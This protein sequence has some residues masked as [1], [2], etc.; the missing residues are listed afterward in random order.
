MKH[1]MITA[2][3]VALLACEQSSRVQDC[4]SNEIAC[5]YDLRHI[6]ITI[7]ENDEPVQLT[8]MVV[9][10]D[11]VIQINEE[12][13]DFNEFGTYTLLSDE[14]M[15][16]VE[17]SGSDVSFS[18]FRGDDRVIDQNYLVGHDC[19]HIQLLEGPIEIKL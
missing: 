14:H 2:L 3:F 6:I 18:G 8:R 19:C 11:G 12:I 16:L 17:Q 9:E 4:D 1:V 13:D 7:A 5:T 10:I 15:N